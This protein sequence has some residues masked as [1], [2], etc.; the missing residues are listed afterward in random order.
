MISYTICLVD[1]EA[2]IRQ[3]ITMGLKKEYQVK[4]FGSAEDALPFIKAKSP[5][6]VL[7]DIGLPGMDGIEALKQIHAHD[8]D[9]SVIMV[10]AFE[11]IQTVISAMKLGAQDY[12]IKPIHMDSLRACVRNSLDTIKMKKEIQALQEKYIKE[13]VPCF[14][15]ES[16]AIQDVMQFVAKVAKSPDTPILICG[17]SGTGKELIAGAIHYKSPQF[18][19]PF[20]TLNCAAIPKELIESELFG[21]ESGAFSGAIASGKKGLI[22]AAAG[23]TLFLDEVGDLSL[24]AQAKL[25]RFLEESKF[26]KV[27]GTEQIEVQ[28]RVVSATNKD[29]IEMVEENLFRLDLFYRLGAI[30]VEIPSLNERREDIIPIAKYFLMEFSGKHAT[31]FTGLNP[32]TEMCLKNRRWTGNIREL[33]NLIERGVLVGTGPNLKAED[34]GIEMIEGKNQVES[35]QTVN[36]DIGAPPEEGVGPP[37][38][39]GVFPPLSE[40]GIYLEALEEHFIKEAGK[41]AKGNDTKAAQ[42]LKMSYYS[43]RYRKKKLAIG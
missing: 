1:D 17:E 18:K 31:T 4:A 42:L 34:L 14:I 6:L 35:P 9:I 25:L 30:Q 43:F 41:M 11:D 29:L 12:V 36:A 32:Q 19:G 27:G 5:D 7:L 2:G 10:S 26:Y 40:E 15:G 16:D 21:Y 13:N 20:I 23:G 24:E 22:E 38:E 37:L 33:R 8:P 28:T 39:E 3:G